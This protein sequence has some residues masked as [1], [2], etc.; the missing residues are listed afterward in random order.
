ML[1]SNIR[2]IGEKLLAVR[3]KAGLTQV[4]VAELAG[5]SDRTYA[6]IERGETNMRV[7]TLLRICKVL[8]VTPD[9]V[10]TQDDPIAVDMETI[11]E[12]LRACSPKDQDTAAQLLSV[13]VNSL[14]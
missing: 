2:E 7:E 4:E 5:L 9:Q 12:E 1:V 10:L 13:Y 3:K 14:K 6:D 11:L 8:K